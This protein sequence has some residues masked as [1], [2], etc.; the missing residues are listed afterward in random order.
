MENIQFMY[1]ECIVNI[2]ACCLYSPVASDDVCVMC[3][4]DDPRI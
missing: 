4:K 2:A 1:E 3:H